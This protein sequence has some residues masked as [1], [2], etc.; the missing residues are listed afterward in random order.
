MRILSSIAVVL[1]VFSLATPVR[2]GM[3][4]DCLQGYDPNRQLGACTAVIRSGQWQGADLAWAYNNRAWALYILR[5]DTEALGDA[6]RS[7][8]LD[9]GNVNAIDPRAHV[10][11]A[12]GRRSEA[13]GE[14]ERAMREGGSTWVRTYQ[15]VLYKQGYYKGAFDG[16]YGPQTREALVACLDDGCRLLE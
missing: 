7:L 12:L 3:R 13:R 14:F 9:P 5:R 2:A 10:L 1:L 4:E 6:D 15:E 11:A 16:A 8:S